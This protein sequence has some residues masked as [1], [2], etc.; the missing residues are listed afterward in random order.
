MAYRR[1]ALIDTGGF[2]ERFPRAFREDA[3]LAL[4]MLDQGWRLAQG[5]RS[6]TH[7]VRAERRWASLRAQAGNADDALM[8]RLHGRDWYRRADAAPGRRAGHWLTTGLA[9]GCAAALAAG[10]L[11]P[12]QAAA[13]CAGTAAARGRL[14]AG[15]CGVRR[16]PDPAWAAN[17]ARITEML[18]TSALI[19]PL[20]VG[21]WAGGWWRAGC[22]AVA[23]PPG[24]GAIRPGRHPGPRRAIQRPARNAS[25][26]CPGWSPRWPGCAGQGCR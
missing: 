9:A 23:A 17:L 15:H 22:P 2:D 13:P 10:A 19:P 12:D 25:S 7:P 16:G 5:Q 1:R 14:A 3:D 21:Y 24:S 11:A 18:I 8:R 6:T 26:R 4:R 20:A